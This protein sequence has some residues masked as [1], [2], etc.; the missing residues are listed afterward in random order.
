MRGAPDDARRALRERREAREPTA[1]R[2]IS[3]AAAISAGPSSGC[4]AKFPAAAITEAGADSPLAVR[5]D[6]PGPRAE[7]ESLFA[8]EGEAGTVTGH[9]E[10]HGRSEERPPE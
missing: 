5:A 1:T 7:V 2:A 6:Q 4:R 9:D 3:S 8:A 10:A